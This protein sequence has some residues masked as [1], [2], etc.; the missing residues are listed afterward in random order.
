[1][2][3]LLGH[4]PL[5]L[6]GVGHVEVDVLHQG[7]QSQL[8]IFIAKG[9]QRVGGIL[10]DGL[11]L[12]GVGIDD[13]GHVGQGQQLGVLGNGGQRHMAHQPVGAQAV[14]LVQHRHEE[15]PGGHVA[16][17]QDVAL[18]AVDDVDSGLG[19][20]VSRRGVHHGIGLLVQPQLLQL[21]HGPGPVSHQHRLHKALLL[22][23]EQA[24]EHIL[25]VSA[26]QYDP[27]R[28]IQ[29]GNTA[30]N[31]VEIFHFHGMIPHFFD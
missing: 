11:F 24:L 29:L 20:I 15:I 6:N 7:H 13:D 22:R 16:P 18:P 26:G 10:D 14:F 21:H 28:G 27:E 8:G 17:H 4:Q 19:H 3:L 5:G 25:A 1:M 23:L 30:D 12:G 31:F 2:G 9:L